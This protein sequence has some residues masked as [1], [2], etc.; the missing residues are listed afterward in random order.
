MAKTINSDLIRG[1]INTIILKA[2][3]DSDRYG[4]DII[5][6]IEV[7]SHGQYI[8][9]QPTLYSCLKRLETQGFIEAYWGEE[10][11]GGGR[12]KYYRLTD[13]GREVF[14]KSQD[15]YEYSRTV[16]DG[17]I[18]KAQY[19]L[20]DY[21]SDDNAESVNGENA[22]T[23]DENDREDATSFVPSDSSDEEEKPAVNDIS[24]PFTQASESSTEHESDDEYY[25][26]TKKIT[27]TLPDQNQSQQTVE[28]EEKT[29]TEPETVVETEPDKQI[30]EKEE[31]PVLHEKNDTDDLHFDTSSAIDAMLKSGDE[32]SYFTRNIVDEEKKNASSSSATSF[33]SDEL[34]S[35]EI[36]KKLEELRS[37]YEKEYDSLK[38]DDSENY[39]N[40]FLKYNVKHSNVNVEKE[41]QPEKIS[42]NDLLSRDTKATTS[43]FSAETQSV[44]IKD[45][46]KM[47]KYGKLSESIAELGE[48][49]HLR[50]S[51]DTKRDYKKM[52]YFRDTYMRLFFAGIMFL[53]ILV[54]LFLVYVI[55]KTVV[56]ANTK[57]DVAVF[58]GSIV[59]NALFPIIAAALFIANPASKKR[60]DFNLKAAFWFRLLIAVQLVLIIYLI[61][62]YMG[63]PITFDKSYFV[64]FAVPLVFVVNLPI[65]ALLFEKLRK[66]KMF[67]AKY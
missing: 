17:L 13:E 58:I 38:D 2:L 61:N 62:V 24:S 57:Y 22:E 6:E 49:P 52:Y 34:E 40:G 53:M 43:S 28:Q 15:E 20:P 8:L 67:E 31:Q 47:R 44:S 11:S 19:D 66:S 55:G 16:I 42:L 41:N 46:I 35:D 12:R 60:N 37:N 33:E 29:D 59:L 50:P 36:S 51:A 54:E 23:E 63:M 45:K 56:L 48:T 4:Y 30:E 10:P 14:K 26:Y 64:T 39:D 1:N 5:K 18:S 9:K 3:Y 27:Y 21:Q 65:S 32:K 7:K 25:T